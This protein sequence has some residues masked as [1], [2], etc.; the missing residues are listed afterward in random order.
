M[1]RGP[2]GRLTVRGIERL[3]AEM[4]FPD[5]LA[6]LR[7]ERGLTQQQ[8]ADRV[9][10]HVIQIRRYERSASQPTLEVIRQIALALSVSA[11]ALIFDQEER[12]PDE[13]L[14]LKFEA[15]RAMTD[16]DKRIIASLLDAYIKK[17]QIEHV[18]AR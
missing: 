6:A 8:L 16:E 4:A 15:V 5:K 18:L 14:R 9:G 2:E 1:S 17:H 3:V 12:G 13:E 10:V 7:K 11:D